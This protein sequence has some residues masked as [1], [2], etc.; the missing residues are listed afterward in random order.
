MIPI[1]RPNVARTG[2]CLFAFFILGTSL[3]ATEDMP[4]DRCGT[5]LRAIR[6]RVVEHND[7]RILG[8]RPPLPYYS[9][10][11]DGRF[12]VH[13]T[14][15]GS[16]AVDSADL[17]GNA[18]PDYVDEC[19][20]AL[21]RSWKLEIDTLRYQAPPNDDTTGGSSAIDVYLRNLGRDGYYGVTNLDKLLSLTPA[22]RYTTWMEIDN[23]FS[24]TDT[25]WSGKQSY[26]TFGVEALRVTCAHELHH[27]IQNGSYAFNL[28]HRMIYELTSTWMEMRAYPEV[29]D[30]AIWTSYLLT[31]PELWPLSKVSALNG[32]CWG[33]FGNVLTGDGTDRMRRTWEIIGQGK[34]PFAAL[35][36]ACNE[37]GS[38]VSSLFCES[39][40]SLYYTGKRGEVNPFMPNARLLPEIKFATDI[41]VETADESVSY[42]LR[43]FEVRA[44][45]TNVPSRTG[46]PVSLGQLISWSADP[47]LLL[48]PDSSM[49]FRTHYVAS[50]AVDDEIIPNSTWGIRYDAKESLCMFNNGLQLLA[51]EAPFPQPYRLSSHQDITIPVAGAN[52]GD[53]VCIYICNLALQPLVR[54]DAAPVR[55]DEEQ[56]C[57]IEAT[58]DVHNNRIGAKC[59]IKDVLPEGIVPGVYLIVVR[60]D[61]SAPRTM[62]KLVIER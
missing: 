14:L 17:N 9:E 5:T 31:R 11:A 8:T 37:S 41:T 30:W 23:D 49:T 54:A 60:P 10:S 1:L 61:G 35:V 52:A 29:R 47:V 6:N 48:R 24:P 18:V 39:L 53:K 19:L 59:N 34:D 2:L 25:T 27:V 16:D 43:P 44:L 28:Q 12:R 7:V 40:S 13:Y 42:T 26:S 32:Y 62:H 45:R 4:H 20:T 21:N 51:T 36:T 58:V 46:Q 38:S 15:S 50:P 22:E 3:Y 57:Y 33:W 56:K 55:K